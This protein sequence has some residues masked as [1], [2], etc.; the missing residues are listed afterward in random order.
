MFDILTL[1]QCLLPEIKV[2][3]MRQLNQIIIAMLSMSGRV[4]MLGISRWTSI[5]GSYR[6]VNRF[7]HTFIPWATV[8]WVFFRQHLFCP[9]DVYLLAGDEV[10]VTKAGKKTYGLD[11]FF[12]SLINNPIS[13]L[14]FFTLSL[15]S[16][17][18]RH[19]FPI[20]I[21]QVIKSDIEATNISSK[22][23][24][25]TKKN[26]DADD[27]KGAKTKIKL[28]LFL[29]LKLLRIKKM[30]N[31]LLQL[32][33]EF[34]PLTYLVLDG[35]FGNNNA[36]QMPLQVNLHIISKLRCDSAL[37]IPY[38][39][40]DP[41]HRSRRKYGDRLDWRNIPACYLRLS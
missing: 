26:V 10:V 40:P 13:G 12:S 29:H 14:S 11:K 23:E 19:S 4:T 38:Q 6:T 21:E 35:H 36:L 22:L 24:I 16:V 18:Q 31:E 15:V 28:R 3:T 34:I 5:G 2:T 30:I 17:E 25:K 32:I 27:Q 1:L 20:Q 39:N 37:Y 33:S 9:N 8:F 7:F 41:N